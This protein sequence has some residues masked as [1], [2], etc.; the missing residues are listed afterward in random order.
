MTTVGEFSS[1]Y[2]CVRRTTL[3][4]LQLPPNKPHLLFR[5]YSR[6]LA[7]ANIDMLGSALIK[8]AMWI[9]SPPACRTAY[10]GAHTLATIA[11]PPLC[12]LSLV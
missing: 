11:H 10:C 12:L 3:R 5:E 1:R 9:K 8:Q 4:Q 6:D 2:L 7:R